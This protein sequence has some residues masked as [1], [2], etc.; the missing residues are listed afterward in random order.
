[1]SVDEAR[2]AEASCANGAIEWR[3][4]LEGYAKTLEAQRAYLDAV[5]SGASDAEPPAPFAVPTG[6]P[7]A[8]A[9]VREMIAALHAATLSALAQHA[10]LPDRLERPRLGNAIVRRETSTATS[11]LDRAL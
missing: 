6:L 1:M 7:P 11:V 5:S 10:D 8:P 9:A 4:A 2:L 3:D